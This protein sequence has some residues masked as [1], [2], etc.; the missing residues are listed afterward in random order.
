MDGD[1]NMV[2]TPAPLTLGLYATIGLIGFALGLAFGTVFASVAI[3]RNRRADAEF[4]TPMTLAEWTATLRPTPA[5]AAPERPSP[6]AGVRRRIG[7]MRAAAG[8]AWSW[9]STASAAWAQ[10]DTEQ[11]ER[12]RDRDHTGDMSLAVIMARLAHEES[13]QPRQLANTKRSTQHVHYAKRPAEAS[14]SRGAGSERPE[15]DRAAASA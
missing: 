13:G 2:V 1:N 3:V 11:R 7:E 9:A 15:L 6:S 8:A 10:V 4:R 12:R 14:G 5:P